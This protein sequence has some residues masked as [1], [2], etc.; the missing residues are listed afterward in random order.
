M[1]KLPKD[2]IDHWPEV[3][4]DVNV[5]ALPIEYLHSLRIT[6]LDGKIWEIDCQSNPNGIDLEDAIETLLEEYEDEITNVDFRLD[7][8]R[9]KRDIQS[10]TKSFLK[11]RK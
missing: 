2:V 1:P 4:R 8:E 11:K 3:L 5:E 9:V 10:R 7:T 6:F